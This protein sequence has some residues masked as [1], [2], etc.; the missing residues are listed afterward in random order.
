[1]AGLDIAPGSLLGLYDLV[2][3]PRDPRGVRHPIGLLLS[4][5]TAAVACGNRS[6][7][8]IGQW[9]AEVAPERMDLTGARHGIPDESTFRRT[10]SEVDGQAVDNALGAWIWAHLPK[11]PGLRAVA[12]DGKALRGAAPKYVTKPVTVALFDVSSGT[13]IAQRQV[14]KKSNEIPAAAPLLSRIPLHDTVVLADALHCQRDLAAYIAGRG[15]F[16]LLCLKANQG[17]MFDTVDAFDWAQAGINATDDTQGHGRAELRT[18]TTISLGGAFTLDF[19][20]A[21][22]VIR[23]ERVRREAGRESIEVVYYLTNLSF[24]HATAAQLAEW[25]RSEWHIEN[26]LHWVRDVTF[27]EDRS[28]IRTGDGPRIM[29]TLRNLVISLLR[30]A[31]ETNIAAGLRRCSNRPEHLRKVLLSQ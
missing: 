10:L 17:G 11:R 30:L 28:Q 7:E 15:G 27:D 12:F 13:V 25:I 19:P 20:E 24:D 3:D 14:A 18:V 29:A 31:G 21:A 26:R 2:E 9:A 8:A 22:Q 6:W 4:V 1:V 5:A 23:V 16:Y